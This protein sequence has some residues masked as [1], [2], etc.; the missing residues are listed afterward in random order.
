MLLHPLT[1]LTTGQLVAMKI[2]VPQ[3]I[4]VFR[5]I[6]ELVCEFEMTVRYGLA[7]FLNSTRHWN[8]IRRLESRSHC[9]RFFIL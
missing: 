9:V 4:D 5:M 6:N 8:R 7:F 3:G 2:H 1:Q